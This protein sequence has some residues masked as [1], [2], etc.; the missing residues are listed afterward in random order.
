MIK[1]C[2]FGIRSSFLYIMATH[3][4]SPRF[5]CDYFPWLLFN[6][7]FSRTGHRLINTYIIKEKWKKM[8]QIDE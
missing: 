3:N 1:M 2:N 8:I 7:Q 4:V 5:T 6:L